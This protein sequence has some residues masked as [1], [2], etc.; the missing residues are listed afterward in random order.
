MFSSHIMKKVGILNLYKSKQTV[1][2]LS[3]VALILGESDKFNLTA[4]V[5]YH[6]KKGNLIRL[7]KGIYA[8]ADYNKFELANKIYTPSYI[9]FETVLRQEGVIFQ[10]YENIFAA[11]YLSR[12][13]ELKNKQKI[14]YKKLKDSILTNDKE[15]LRIDN[16][17]I[18][19]KERAFMD[20]IYLNGNYFFD[21]LENIDWG[22][23]ARLLDVYDN[24]QMI[25]K[26]KSYQCLTGKNIK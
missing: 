22:K 6:I 5:Q 1:F 25:K 10:H 12:E 8:K 4:K 16:F 13:I 19:G 26:L 15:V 17:F 18:A 3:E 14:I 21:N 23:C 9:S 2:T 7:R 11:S 24:K 20:T